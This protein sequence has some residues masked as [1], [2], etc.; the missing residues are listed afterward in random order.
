MGASYIYLK[1]NIE[2]LVCIENIKIPI[3]NITKIH[4]ILII[5]E[6][7]L[8]IES[9]YQGTIFITPFS[10]PLLPAMFFGL[11]LKV[12]YFAS[13]CNHSKGNNIFHHPSPLMPLLIEQA[14]CHFRSFWQIL[15]LTSNFLTYTIPNIKLSIFYILATPFDYDMFIYSDLQSSQ[16][17]F[18]IHF[19]MLFFI[20]D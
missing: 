18:L 20:I 12:F 16:L 6:N 19:D 2:K 14:S 5:T 3:I 17:F 10:M 4:D 11:L 1:N 13:L 8:N 9:S 7:T 15:I